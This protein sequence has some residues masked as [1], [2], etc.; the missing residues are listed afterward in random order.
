MSL[1]HIK[2]KLGGGVQVHFKSTWNGQDHPFNT[3]IW[4]NQKRNTLWLVWYNHH[5]FVTTEP[6]SYVFL[7]NC[8][9]IIELC[10]DYYSV[11]M[12]VFKVMINRLQGST[13][14]GTLGSVEEVVKTSARQPSEGTCISYHP[15]NFHGHHSVNTLIIII[16]MGCAYGRESWK[17]SQPLVETL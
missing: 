15:F 17:N 13:L 10:I 4:E 16:T 11:L 14:F 12:L 9:K 5:L 7:W 2:K 8:T 1:S 6:S 3:L